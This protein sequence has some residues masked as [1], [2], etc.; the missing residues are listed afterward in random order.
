MLSW[1]EVLVAPT[2]DN[3]S[4]SLSLRYR[5]S[6]VYNDLHSTIANA[7]SQK[8]LKWWA[9][10]NGVDMAMNWPAFEV[11][12]MMKSLDLSSYLLLPWE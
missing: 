11:S 4:L 6:Q 1:P 2:I 7:D 12:A 8:D 3:L 9:Q 5:Y 10:T